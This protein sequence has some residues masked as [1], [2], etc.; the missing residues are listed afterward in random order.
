[1]FWNV[2]IVGA[3]LSAIFV[4]TLWRDRSIRRTLAAR[5]ALIR[6][7]LKDNLPETF[8]V[9]EVT[10][11]RQHGCNLATLYAEDY[12]VRVAILEDVTE[13]EL[14]RYLSSRAHSAETLPVLHKKW[15]YED[16]CKEVAA[17]AKENASGIGML[18]YTF[19][20]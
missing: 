2:F 19:E 17:I 1:M 18:S 11:H 15:N 7:I 12:Y 3:L 10:K 6:Q 4:I 5:Q 9:I 13:A 14:T 16:E 20:L 8:Y